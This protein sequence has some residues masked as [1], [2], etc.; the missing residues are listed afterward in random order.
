MER[1]SPKNGSIEKETVKS[2]LWKELE[3]KIQDPKTLE[4][5]EPAVNKALSSVSPIFPGLFALTINVRETQVNKVIGIIK[6]DA[7]G[8]SCCFGPGMDDGIGIFNK[9][10]YWKQEVHTC[11][12]SNPGQWIYPSTEKQSRWIEKQLDIAKLKLYEED[13]GEECYIFAKDFKLG[14]VFPEQNKKDPC[15]AMYWKVPVG[16]LSAEVPVAKF[17]TES[18]DKCNVSLGKDRRNFIRFL[19]ESFGIRF[20]EDDIDF[21]DPRV[22]RILSRHLLAKKQETE[23][24]LY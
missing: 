2:L 19:G 24:E 1:T 22:M 5:L 9:Y 6:D 14:L 10:Y 17:V 18:M 21:S 11:T 23:H 4:Q 20:P 12:F 7:A 16:I 3:S 8:V 15:Y 13:F